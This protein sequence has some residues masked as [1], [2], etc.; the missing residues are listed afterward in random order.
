MLDVYSG[1]ADGPGL[2]AWALAR[3]PIAGSVFMAHGEPGAVEGLRERLAAAGF[4][5][6]QLIAPQLDESFRLRKGRAEAQAGATPRMAPE[7]TAKLD[8]H[9]ARAQL[10]LKLGEVLERAPDDAAREALIAQLRRDLGGGQVE[11]GPG[12]GSA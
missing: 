12:A 4:P 2:E 10:L 8:W 1:H 6:D 3:R 9:N 11:A 5:A 7:A